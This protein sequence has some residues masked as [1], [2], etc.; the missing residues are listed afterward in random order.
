MKLLLTSFTPND[1]HDAALAELVGKP[2][3]DLKFAYI[4]NAYDVYDDEASLVEGRQMLRD[5][6]YDFE[7]VDLRRWRGQHDELA[8]LLGSKDVF[9]LAGG[10]PFYLRWQMRESGADRIITDCVR[11]G[12]VYCG[13]SAAAVVAGPTLRHFDALDDPG[14]AGEVIW[15]GLGLTDIVIVPH[16][17]NADFGAGC[18]SAGEH[19]AADGYTTQWITD[20]QAF[21]IDGDTTRVIS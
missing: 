12:A 18:R 1:A 16:T 10:N 19:C 2:L 14:A 6:G 15:D 17:D 4:E 3:P 13:A 9:L 11:R 20:A 5:K 7:L 8:A 21:L